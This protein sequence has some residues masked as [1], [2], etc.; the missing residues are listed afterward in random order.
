MFI[1]LSM[2]SR[3]DWIVA[4]LILSAVALLG[5][6]IFITKRKSSPQRIQLKRVSAKTTY[7]N[8]EEYEITED[9]T[10]VIKVKVHRTAQRS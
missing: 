1:G 4:G 8:L 3:E 6:T 10:G 2:P 9:K 5:V 7:S